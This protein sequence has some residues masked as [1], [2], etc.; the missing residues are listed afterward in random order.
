MI[1]RHYRFLF[2]CSVFLLFLLSNC[3]EE[4]TMVTELSESGYS[5][6]PTPRQVELAGDDIG[7]SSE[8]IAVSKDVSGDHIAINTLF[9]DMKELY[10]L[11]IE[12]G[13]AKA[14]VIHL[15]VEDGAVE[16]GAK[17][18]I[19]RQGYLLELTP[20]SIEITGNSEQ[21]L[22]YG[23]QTLVQLVKQTSGGEYLLPTGTIKDWPSGQLRFLHWD[24]KHH[25]D[26]ME[27]LKRYLDWS[28]RF[29]VN[30]ISFELADKFSYPS[31][32]VIGAPG[33]FTPEELQEL[34]D[35]ARE[36]YI[37][38]V[39]NIQSPAHMCYALKHPEFRDVRATCDRCPPE[40]L[41][42]QLCLCNEKSYDLLFDMYQDVIDATKGVDYFHVSTD[43]V[44][45]A[46]ICDQC[47][48]PYKW[49]DLSADSRESRSLSWARFAG[50]ANDFLKKQN[51]RMIAWVE[52][53]LLTKD[54][55]K[56]PADIIDGVQRG[57]SF[58][59]AEHE[60]GMDGLIYVSMQGGE[61][62]IPNNF[63]TED[64]NVIEGGRL[65]SAFENISYP[66]KDT[67]GGSSVWE[68]EHSPLGVFGAAWDDSGLHNETFWLGWSTVAQYGWTPGTPAVKQHVSEFVDTYYGNDVEGMVEIY[69]DLQKQADFFARSWDQVKV[70]E[71]KPRYGYSDRLYEEPRNRTRA[72]L[73]QPALPD[74][75]AGSSEIQVDPVYVNKYDTLARNARQLLEENQRLRK[76]IKENMQRAD[77]NEY[78]LEVLLSL[79]KFTR[80]HN[81]MVVTL[82]EIENSLQSASEA[83]V[84]DNPEEAV[85][86]LV[87]AHQQADEVIQ[88]RE[89][90]YDDFKSVWEKSRFPK[91]RSVGG[92]DYY[93]E[94]DDIKT[95]WAYTRP[96]LTFYIAP[97]ER[98]NMEKWKEELK[99][100]VREYAEKYELS[101]E[102]IE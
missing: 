57:E 15:S 12:Q 36:R 80:H 88:D 8:W 96:D 48:P 53:P 46:G 47:E 17:A 3:K 34:V 25:Q 56:L 78:N 26:R 24:T 92:R 55:S 91:G 59:K 1:I 98:I 52:Y 38:I 2:Y 35:Y 32:P 76:R 75:S 83:A 97:E 30:M 101:V 50:R 87:S 54:I 37:Q 82:K 94:L 64:E 69:Q 10:G 85:E 9:E 73:P 79:A 68:T 45:Y 51:R 23:V 44:Y 84:N 71:L 41:N 62:L 18:E 81:Q 58:I 90:A 99:G 65:Q 13:K 5:V 33:A 67:V 61:R 86:Y 22:Y 11:E 43:E 29:K 102:A 7:L 60:I 28:A 100:I 93:H 16:T 89:E 14:K 95:H 72:T 70:P 66:R 6:I 74:L 27:T 4:A 21:G 40:G 49:E 31:H 77:R 19:D 42:Y 63:G 20:S 39:P